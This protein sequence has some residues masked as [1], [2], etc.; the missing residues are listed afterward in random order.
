[1]LLG[2]SEA[3]AFLENGC[4]FMSGFQPFGFLAATGW[5]W[6]IQHQSFLEGRNGCFID[7]VAG[8]LI[9]NDFVASILIL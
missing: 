6:K 9:L 3:G 7:F 8:A 2:R 5:C 4:L 1:M